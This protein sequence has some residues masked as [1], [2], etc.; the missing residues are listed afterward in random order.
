MTDPSA[1]KDTALRV[2][3]VRRLI[4]LDEHQQLTGHHLRTTAAA[5][6][7]HRRTV[8]RWKTNA[9]A[10][11]GIYTPAEHPHLTLSTA[12]R[13]ALARWC[14]NIAATHRELLTEGHL[15]ADY[16]T[17]YRAVTRE[18]TPGFLAGLR[19]GEHA[20][21]G[22][23]VHNT[24]SRGHR[25]EAWEAD[26]VKATVW[27]NVAGH[28]R[29]PWITWFADCAHD[30]ICGLA[31]SAQTPSRE[32]ILVAL[33]DALLRE[34]PHG[35]F[36]G[37]PQLV[38][39]DG[40]QD[41]LCDTVGQALG[42]FGVDRIKLP[43]GHPELKGTI[44][45]INGAVKKM[46]FPSLPGTTQAPRT[47]RL[48]RPAR[49][50]ELLTYEA[51]VQ[52][53][54]DW[55]HE[56][57]FDHRIRDLGNRTPYQSWQADGTPLYDITPAALHTYTL[58]L[59]GKTLTINGNGIHW[60]KRHYT[61]DW[62]HGRVGTKVRMRYMPHHYHQIEVYDARTGD[63]YGPAFWQ[64]AA[65]EQQKKDLVHA[66]GCEAARLRIQLKKTEKQR[67]ERFAALTVPTVPRALS[68][69]T[70]AQAEEALQA[71]RQAGPVGEKAR[72]DLRPLPT[73]TA[74]WHTD[75]PAVPPPTVEAPPA[76]PLPPPTSSWHPRPEPPAHQE[77]PNAPD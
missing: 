62:M 27:V 31:I 43:P 77:H 63:H 71:R 1:T 36:G 47:T 68:P 45:S 58:E 11:H 2:A 75:D 50:E 34:P 4:F 44:E 52:I 35:P 59:A 32:A 61:A 22:F 57:N 13:D 37:L 30:C 41:F 10:H 39:I 73:P 33:R 28:R 16:T 64:N 19:E 25:N 24:R 17:F 38:R 26:H 9:A 42:V 14:G 20:R 40:G 18:L 49:D 65:N 70:S 5:F 55:V 54:R 12:M 46:S 74:S 76:R 8:E 66:A 51:F 60:G 23:D 69:L 56:W 15:A 6:G 67:K 29:K 72:S 53:V 3:A 7:V 48:R 21:R